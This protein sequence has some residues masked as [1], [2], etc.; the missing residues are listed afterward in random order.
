MNKQKAFITLGLL[1]A[2]TI[3]LPAARADEFDQAT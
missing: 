2:F 1:L 3:I